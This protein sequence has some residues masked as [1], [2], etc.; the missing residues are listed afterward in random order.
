M[1][2][3][4]CKVEVLT[5][6]WPRNTPDETALGLAVWGLDDPSRTDVAVLPLIEMICSPNDACERKRTT[7]L[8]TRLTLTLC[9]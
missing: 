7:D 9:N 3:W 8:S 5:I 6:V 1:R 4:F 2:F